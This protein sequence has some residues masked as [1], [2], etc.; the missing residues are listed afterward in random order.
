MKLIDEYLK[1]IEKE[2]QSTEKKIRAIETG[3]VTEVKDGVVF[4]D[5]LDEISYGELIRFEGN[6]IQILHIHI[7]H[8]NY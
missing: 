2:L 5:G 1:K 6:Q 4:L 8:M 3:L 7:H